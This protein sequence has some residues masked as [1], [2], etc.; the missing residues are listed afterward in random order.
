MKHFALVILMSAAVGGCSLTLPVQGQ[1]NGGE[2][3][4]TGSATGYGD[5]S[6]TLTIVSNTGIQ[7][8]GVFVYLTRRTGR[9][10]FHCGKGLSGPFEFVSTGTRGTGTG[11]LGRRPFTFTFG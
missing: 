5:G 3:S 2:G 11:T 1:M 7:C 10:T 8:E 9:G 4:F 6:G